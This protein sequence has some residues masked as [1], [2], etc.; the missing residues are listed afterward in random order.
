MRNGNST[1]ANRLGKVLS[2]LGL[3][4]LVIAAGCSS[5]DANLVGHTAGNT[6]DQSAALAHQDTM[7]S[8]GLSLT[9]GDALGTVIF[10]DRRA[11]LARNTTNVVTQM[12]TTDQV[13]SY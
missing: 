10:T 8:Q 11:V 5:P 1:Y 4:V 13:H 3:A 9:S 7:D 12:A 2:G 6:A